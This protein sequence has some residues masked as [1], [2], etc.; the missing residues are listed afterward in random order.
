LGFKGIV[1]AVVQRVTKGQVT[2]GPN[3]VGEIRSG[4]CIL[5]GVGKNDGESDADFLSEKIK[6]LRVFED[7]SGKMNLSLAAAGGEV[8]I[9]SQFTLYGDWRKGNRPSFTDAASPT[10][11]EKLYEHFVKRF[12]DAGVS[13]ATGQFQARMK[14]SLV[15]DGPVTFVLES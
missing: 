1:R 6:N 9:V 7:H 11:A 10:Q 3:I 2:V 5:L 8:L 12:R 4:L 13:V 14:V 15:N